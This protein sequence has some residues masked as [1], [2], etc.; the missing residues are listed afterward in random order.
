MRTP[1]RTLGLVALVAVAIT[2][3]APAANCALRNPRRQIEEIFPDYTNLKSVIATIDKDLKAEIERV[4]GSELT[5]SDVGKHTAYIVL[6]GDVP[7]GIVHARTETG[8]RGSIELVW[9]MDLDMR[10]KDFR[11]QRSRDKHTDVIKSDDFRNQMAGRDLSDLRKL[12]TAGNDDI[13]LAALEI[14][15]SARAIAHAAVLC[16]VKTRIITDEAF[17]ETIL[18]ARLRGLAHRYFPGTARVTRIS[19]P[20]P[21]SAVD[22]VTRAIATAP[23]QLDPDSFAI[24]RAFDAA[25]R[26]LGMLALAD[27][28]SHPGRPETWWAV[29]TN[30]TIRE[31]L[32]VGDV[33]EDTRAR[34]SEL[35]G[36]DLPALTGRTPDTSDAPSRCGVEVLAV[37]SIHDMGS[38]PPPAE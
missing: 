5:I 37:L 36:S 33:D 30:G 2:E 31:I 11:V 15:A 38:P 27:W 22:A 1:I 4:L 6:K 21:E 34:L 13:D 26:P 10:I 19:V 3:S 25:D 16:G 8:A 17:H 24:L 18:P 35:R 7:I 29:A 23:R 12:L 9:A 32:V 14:P 20:Y 28:T